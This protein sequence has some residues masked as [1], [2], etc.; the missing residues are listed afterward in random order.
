MRVTGQ[1]A[2]A[3]FTRPMV[4]ILGS[5]AAIVIECSNLQPGSGKLSWDYVRK[6]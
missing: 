5:N 1:P 3:T 4:Y 6:A 2:T